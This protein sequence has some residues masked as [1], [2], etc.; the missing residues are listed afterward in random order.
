MVWASGSK[1]LEV[2]VKVPPTRCRRGQRD[3]GPRGVEPGLNP[4]PGVVDGIG[5]AVE[6]L[7]GQL[8]MLNISAVPPP[9]WRVNEP[10]SVSL[11][12]VTGPISPVAAVLEV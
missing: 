1:R 11:L 7:V 3:E 4:Q 9:T 12:L 5:Q 6:R 8:D 2:T 10:V